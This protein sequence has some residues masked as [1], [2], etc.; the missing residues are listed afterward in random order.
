LPSWAVW[1]RR[2]V[3]DRRG[4]ESKETLEIKKESATKPLDDGSQRGKTIIKEKMH[5]HL[6]R[7]ECLSRR[8]GD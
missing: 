4:D 7:V 6:T 2:D 3:N 8:S 1:T 5:Q